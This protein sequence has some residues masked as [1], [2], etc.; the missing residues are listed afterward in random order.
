[1][2][3][4]MTTHE[5][6]LTAALRAADEAYEAAQAQAGSAHTAIVEKA[7]AALQEA[8]DRH[9]ATM[10]EA[11]RVLRGKAER[12]AT[13]RARAVEQAW[14]EFDQAMCELYA[15]PDAEVVTTAA[16]SLELRCGRVRVGGIVQMAKDAYRVDGLPAGMV[17]VPSLT[18][19]R[20]VLWSTLQPDE[21]AV[22]A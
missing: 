22:V 5:D 8:V 9:D 10:A 13:T 14:A 21:P 7:S 20:T 18:K 6:R 11:D 12:A 1:M 3:N 17:F 16:G 19:A 2:G 4:T 15:E